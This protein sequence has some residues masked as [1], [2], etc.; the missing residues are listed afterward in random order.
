MS[1]LYIVNQLTIEILS[2]DYRNIDIV[3]SR[4]TRVGGGDR[5]RVRDR[6]HP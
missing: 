3:R 2:I 5:R 1:I 4:T 6:Y